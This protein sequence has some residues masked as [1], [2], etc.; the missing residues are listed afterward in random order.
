MSL[1]NAAVHFPSVLLKIG[2]ES[3]I[4]LLLQCDSVDS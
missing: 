4:I 3:I 2:W 1:G